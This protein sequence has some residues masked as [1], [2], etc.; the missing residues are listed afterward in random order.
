MG[1]EAQQAQKMANLPEILYEFS[2]RP[3]SEKYREISRCK[4]QCCQDLQNQFSF[5]MLDFSGTFRQSGKIAG[6]FVADGNFMA[7][8]NL[9]KNYCKMS[10]LSVSLPLEN[11]TNL[12]TIHANFTLDLNDIIHC[13]PESCQVDDLN[14]FILK[15][16]PVIT[17]L[18]PFD[19]KKWRYTT[20]YDPTLLDSNFK[21]DTILGYTCLAIWCLLLVFSRSTDLNFQKIAKN[22]CS[23]YQPE[24]HLKTLS[25][26]MVL[27]LV[28]LMVGHIMGGVFVAY[29]SNNVELFLNFP[30]EYPITL[31]IA[32]G[33]LAVDNFYCVGGI[34]SGYLLAKKM[35]EVKGNVGI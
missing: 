24:F 16:K 17:N 14:E 8:K 30:T 29:G 21:V 35:G 13:V 28:W 1:L 6:D 3:I 34:L 5:E 11:L 33:S 15:L 26:I 9:G 12:D 4:N 19:I 25:G 10:S 7:C 2:H 23:N 31:M 22:L 18:L 20:C 32:N 27:T